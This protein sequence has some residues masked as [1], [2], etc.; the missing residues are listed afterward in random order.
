M[1]VRTNVLS[2]M[3]LSSLLLQCSLSDLM[4]FSDDIVV[5]WSFLKWCNQCNIWF[6]QIS[7]FDFSDGK[8]ELVKLDQCFWIFYFFSLKRPSSKNWNNNVK[9]S[10]ITTKVGL[11]FFSLHFYCITVSEKQNNPATKAK[12]SP[13]NFIQSFVQN[14]LLN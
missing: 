7:T 2:T 9:S 13:Q 4:M 10:E 5:P 3:L 6:L 14:I 8:F 11:I 12:I 1:S